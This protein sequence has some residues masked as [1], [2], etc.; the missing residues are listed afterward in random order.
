MAKPFLK[1]HDKKQCS[2]QIF[3]SAFVL[4]LPFTYTLYL[5][6]ICHSLEKSNISKR[7]LVFYKNFF[8]TKLYWTHL[9][10]HDKKLEKQ[11]QSEVAQTRTS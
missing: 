5:Y 6:R 3:P 2:L 1:Q 10:G 8:R 9:Y 7:L 4:S 11:G